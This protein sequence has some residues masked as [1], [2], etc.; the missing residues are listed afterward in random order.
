MGTTREAYCAA[1]VPSVLGYQAHSAPIGFQF[2]TAAQFPAAY[3]GDAFIA[4]RGSWNRT[5]PAGY[6][7]VRLKFADGQPVAFEDFLTGFLV[8][9]NAIPEAQREPGVTYQFARLAGV[10]NAIDG[11]LLVADDANGM[12][13]RI[14]YT[15]DTS[16]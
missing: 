11:A 16:R 10:A 14:A 6:K 8:E 2:Y 3:H 4:L 15:G 7:V 1:T 5:P 12:I 13:Y 9:E